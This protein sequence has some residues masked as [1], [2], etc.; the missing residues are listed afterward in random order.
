MLVHEFDELLEAQP[1]KRFRVVTA[2]GRSLLVPSREFAWHPPTSRTIWIASVD[3]KRTH[4]ID[5]QTVTKFVI[6]EGTNGSAKR[7]RR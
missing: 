3:G 2:D 1:F 7:K 4:M 6:D 5:L